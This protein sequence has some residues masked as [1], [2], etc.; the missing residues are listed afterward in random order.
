MLRPTRQIRL[1]ALT[2]I[3]LWLLPGA[4]IAV[5]GDAAWGLA[6][7][8]AGALYQLFR[9]V[10]AID[11]L[12]VWARS[13]LG[14]PVP[15]ASGVWDLIFSEINRRSRLMKDQRERLS[16]AL[17]RFVEAGR[18]MPDGVIYMGP[19][20]VIDWANPRAEE[21]F[22]IVAARDADAA[23]TNLVRDPDFVTYLEAGDFTE[24]LIMTPLRQPGLTLMVQLVP[25]AESRCMLLSRDISHLERL[26]TMRRDFVANVSHELRTPLTVVLGFIET[27]A[28]DD[29]G[30]S[31]R[32]RLHYLALAR[33]QAERMHRLIL[34][35]LVLSA[36]ETGAPLPAEEQV[37]V[38]ALLDRV[39]R[40]GI[41]LSAGRHRLT[42]EIEG[43]HWMRGSTKELHSAFANLVSNAI[44]Y[45]EAGGAIRL[46]WRSVGGDVAFSVR[47][48]G[49]GID[50]RHLPRLTERFYRVDRGRS[51]ESGGTGLGL[52]IVKHV[53]GRHQ[54][55][56]EIESALG[57]GSTFRAILPARRV[58]RP[59]SD[60]A[61]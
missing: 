36:L 8:L 25:Y 23:L 47:D 53:L 33:E 51:R 29:E 45:S 22:G 39:L 48:Q 59:A 26:E 52:A 5:L 18:A 9:H 30:L 31:A 61:A 4:L 3:A 19:G 16:M 6:A 34:D 60:E 15:V 24:P 58:I 14:T 28:D 27:L 35:L 49:E 32:D 12:V 50:A 54:G 7:M 38:P 2:E 42:L 20:N 56:L 57:T 11:S 44:R 21:H 55:R 43:P 37:D 46:A 41:A 13:P 10:A 17:D 1:R 40:E